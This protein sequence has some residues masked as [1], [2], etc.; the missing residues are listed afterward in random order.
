LINLNNSER[1]TYIE[2]WILQMYNI[3]IS[4]QSIIL[5]D[6]KHFCTYNGMTQKKWRWLTIHVFTNNLFVSHSPQI[7]STAVKV[8]YR[9]CE[10]SDRLTVTESP[11]SRFETVNTIQSGMDCCKRRLRMKVNINVVSPSLT[12]TTLTR[13]RRVVCDR[14]REYQHEHATLV[15]SVS[16]GWTHASQYVSSV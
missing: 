10:T 7:F 11:L 3:M 1:I 4:D 6:R 13:R 12:L 2:M 9:G 16:H 14:D 8:S 5:K 15:N